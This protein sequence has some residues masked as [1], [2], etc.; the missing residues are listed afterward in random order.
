MSDATDTTHHG[1]PGRAVVASYGLPR[2]I[3]LGILAVLLAA[4]V[5]QAVDFQVILAEGT[6]AGYFAFDMIAQASL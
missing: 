3:R 2:G 5:G 1:E 6:R 4:T